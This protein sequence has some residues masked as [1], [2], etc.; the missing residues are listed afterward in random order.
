MLTERL[1]VGT[2]ETLDFF[3]GGGGAARVALDDD[4]LFGQGDGVAKL[5]GGGGGREGAIGTVKNLEGALV[6]AGRGLLAGKLD[7]LGDFGE[8]L[9]MDG[10]DFF[11]GGGRLGGGGID[12]GGRRISL[13]GVARR[14]GGISCLLGRFGFGDG[15]VDR[16]QAFGRADILGVDGEDRLELG[17]GGLQVAFVARLQGFGEEL[18][19]AGGGIAVLGDERACGKSEGDG[20]PGELRTVEIFHEFGALKI[21]S[22]G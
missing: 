9:L 22:W 15:G 14:L 12:L 13:R 7:G 8:K 6:V 19:L 3:L 5:L 10:G 18:R 2:G 4:I 20:Y 11:E 1:G 16:R 17:L 21:I